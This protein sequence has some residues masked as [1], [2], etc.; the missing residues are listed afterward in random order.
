[1]S[2]LAEAAAAMQRAEPTA[3]VPA[4]GRVLA[5]AFGEANAELLLVDFRQRVLCPLGHPDAEPLP[6]DRT[7]AGRAFSSQLTQVDRR[8]DRQLVYLPV[9]A[10]GE[11]LGVLALTLPVDS[12]ADR[13]ELE[14]LAELTAHLV[15]AADMATDAYTVAARTRPL[16]VAAEMQWDL[17]PARAYRS[18]RVAVAGALEPAYS[19]GGDSFDWS[20][21]DGRLFLSVLDADG[22][23]V[24]AAMTT[25]L[26]VTALRNAR[27]SGVELATQA[28]L[29]DQALYAQHAGERFVSAVL[30]C[31]D[32]DTGRLLAVDAGSPQVLL[33]RGSAVEPVGLDPQLP[34]GMFEDTAYATES[35]QLRPGDRLVLVSDG[36]Q[37]AA[38]PHGEPFG[39]ARL[40]GLLADSVNRAPAETVRALMRAVQD[41]QDRP[42]PHDD[43]VAVCLDWLG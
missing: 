3:L 18:P 13:G 35:V 36:L 33:V 41:H 26:A 32:L 1:M 38:S 5:A 39:D 28:R 37:S 23:G 9:S 8:Q 2:L 31:L 24:R 43:V 20:N 14:D 25:T 15:V 34:L 11:R 29:A 16:T 30:T 7:L 10:R 21:G 22:R 42:D 12:G 6:V 27:R 17:L 40:S 4:L 19:V